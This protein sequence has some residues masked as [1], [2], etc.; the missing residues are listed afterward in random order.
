MRS[1]GRVQVCA[2]LRER[3][4]ERET[5][6]ERAWEPEPVP[7]KA[8]GWME[9]FQAKKLSLTCSFSS[10]RG[11]RLHNWTGLHGGGGV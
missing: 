4:R 7:Q 1:D 3:K 5:A 9:A 10:G 6:Q 2:T 8:G 11:R